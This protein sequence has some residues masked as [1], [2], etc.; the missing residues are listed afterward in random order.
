M[1]EIYLLFYQSTLPIFITVDLLL[2]RGS[3]CIHIW[4]G[5][6]ENLLTKLLGTFITLTVIDKADCM[7]N[8]LLV[9]A[10]NQMTDVIL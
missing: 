7:T 5:T 8:V 4:Y 3:P 2:L 9:N 10:S 1:T 6:M